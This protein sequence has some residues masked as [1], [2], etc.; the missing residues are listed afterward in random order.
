MNGALVFLRGFGQME[1][2]AS[3][4]K[5]DRSRMARLATLACASLALVTLFTAVLATAP[6]FSPP[7]VRHTPPHS[8][9]SHHA[10]MIQSKEDRQLCQLCLRKTCSRDAA[11][12]VRWKYDDPEGADRELCECACCGIQCG[13]RFSMSADGEWHPCSVH[14][15]PPASPGAVRATAAAPSSPAPADLS[16]RGGHIALL[17]QAGISSHDL[18]TNDQLFNWRRQ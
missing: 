12:A 6:S 13:K 5:A 8:T 9:D 3:V 17:R 18:R 15:A 14:R 1:T 11:C 7:R 16:A 10:E 2:I 4:Q